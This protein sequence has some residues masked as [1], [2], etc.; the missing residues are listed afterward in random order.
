MSDAPADADAVVAERIR[1]A[2][3]TDARVAEMHVQVEVSG[4]RVRLSGPVGSADRREATESVVLE[5]LPDA[6]V[7]ND[8][9]VPELDREPETED[10]S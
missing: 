2:L 10:L 5:V 3:A 7:R 9:T 1:H 6:E 8:T 4:R